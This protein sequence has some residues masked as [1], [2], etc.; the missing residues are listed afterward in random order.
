MPRPT[1]T[2][3]ISA[4][5]S[6]NIP[7]AKKQLTDL[8]TL[9]EA[10]IV[11]VESY[12]LE[13][14]PEEGLDVIDLSLEKYTSVMQNL[15]RLYQ[16]GNQEIDGLKT[17][18]RALRENIVALKDRVKEQL[19]LEKKTELEKEDVFIQNSSYA[20]HPAAKLYNLAQENHENDRGKVQRFYSNIQKALTAYESNEIDTALNELQKKNG[21]NIAEKT[22]HEE[23]L[24]LKDEL[25]TIIIN[26]A[27]KEFN[28]VKGEQIQQLT[29]L[30][31][32]LQNIPGMQDDKAPLQETLLPL[33][34]RWNQYSPEALPRS[35]YQA[36]KNDLVELCEETA[37][38][39]QTAVGQVEEIEQNAAQKKALEEQVQTLEEQHNTVSDEVTELKSQ[40]Q[41]SLKTL[42]L[43][44][45]KLLND[46][47]EL[48]DTLPGSDN[49]K[50][51]ARSSIENV[52]AGIKQI[53]QDIPTTVATLSVDEL[54]DLANNVP[55]M[56]E[57]TIKAAMLELQNLGVYPP[58]NNAQ[59][60]NPHQNPAS[61]SE[62]NQ[63]STETKE[64][65]KP[66][67][68]A[69]VYRK[70]ADLFNKLAEYFNRFLIQPAVKAGQYIGRN[71]HSLFVGKK[72]N[73][74]ASDVNASQE[75]TA[76]VTP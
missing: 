11:K 54:E 65:Q 22:L 39:I 49:E 4:K 75:Q 29:Q 72:A 71:V 55:D 56:V 62:D 6:Q 73:E 14:L 13:N 21:L 12:L 46:Q 3:A 18:V 50:A 69:K 5:N 67:F 32:R 20:E 42:Y 1:A 36:V 16:N 41:T 26:E 58:S 63:A 9:L 53:I 51:P 48:I 76:T 45:I 2:T 25:Q 74:Q 37:K 10:S 8:K 17:E 66:G 35:S 61:T 33:L 27:H 31:E 60:V 28:N 34:V 70:I 57:T 64:N 19:E 24:Q 44:Q 7:A 68:F 15:S 59:T 43:S 23:A 47:L 40:F 52:I 38:V 30:L